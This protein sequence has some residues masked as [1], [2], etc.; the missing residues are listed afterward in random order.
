M[1]S[2]DE[3]TAVHMRGAKRSCTDASPLGV[4]KQMR[5]CDAWSRIETYS[6]TF[7]THCRAIIRKSAPAGCCGRAGGP[8]RAGPWSRAGGPAAACSAAVERQGDVATL[9]PTRL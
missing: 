4:A 7:D 8:R 6:T 1:T 2:H 5:F 3:P 9:V